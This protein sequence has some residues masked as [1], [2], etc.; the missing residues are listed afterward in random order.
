M[1]MKG[2]KVGENAPAAGGK[3]NVQDVSISKTVDKSTPKLMEA[4]VLGSPA[5]RGSLTTLVPA[6]TCKLGARY[7]RAELDT[8]AMRFEMENVL[9]SS[10]AAHSGGGSESRPM[11]SLSLNYEKIVWK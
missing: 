1:R 4:K 3:A 5:P 7:P 8:G 11:E 2:S 9:I 6:G 10:C